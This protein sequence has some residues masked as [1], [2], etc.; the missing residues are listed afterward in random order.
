MTLPARSP[1][2]FEVPSNYLPYELHH[3]Y[4][5]ARLIE[6]ARQN[7]AL[8]APIYEAY[9]DRIYGYCL[10]RCENAQEAEDLCSQ[11]FTRALVGLHT[12]RG[13]M[14]A[15]WLFQIAHHVVVNH[16]R[17]SRAPL[18]P[19]DDLD[20]PD[21]NALEAIERAE[22]GR[23]LQNLMATLPDEQR[24]LLALT[25]DAELTSHEI[26]VLMGKSA[27]AVRTQVHRIIKGLRERYIQIMG[28]DIR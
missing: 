17:K 14:F 9:F 24:D 18:I 16:Y 2:Q 15:A 10:R 13:G 8:F 20:L 19:L 12:Y 7:P 25:L 21:E 26:G 11:V 1:A 4:D 22:D 27:G 3:P 5:E 28:D 6:L 23:I